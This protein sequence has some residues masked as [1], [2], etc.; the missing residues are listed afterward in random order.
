[1]KQPSQISFPTTEIGGAVKHSMGIANPFRDNT[2][3]Q[4]DPNI[5]PTIVYFKQATVPVHSDPNHFPLGSLDSGSEVPRSRQ[6]IDNCTKMTL[7]GPIVTTIPDSNR[8]KTCKI[9]DLFIRPSDIS[10]R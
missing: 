5:Q 4:T 3:N 10:Y 1:M 2:V 8:A 7:Q 6:N 9:F